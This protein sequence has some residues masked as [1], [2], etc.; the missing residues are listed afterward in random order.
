VL[1]ALADGA[2]VKEQDDEDFGR[3]HVYR[4]SVNCRYYDFRLYLV[5]KTIRRTLI[6]VVIPPVADTV[7]GS[8]DR[9]R[10]TTR[11]VANE[12][13]III[14]TTRVPLTA[15]V[16]VVSRRSCRVVAETDD[17]RSIRSARGD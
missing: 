8:R 1:G 6:V 17:H 9:R 16:A 2:R 7:T 4:T 11:S 10:R 14:K 3:T 15:D 5:P 12:Y 13:G